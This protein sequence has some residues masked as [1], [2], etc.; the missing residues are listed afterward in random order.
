MWREVVDAVCSRSFRWSVGL[1]HRESFDLDFFSEQEVNSAYLMR[2]LTSLKVVLG[3]SDIIHEEQF[4]FNFFV[5][6]YINK[7]KLKSPRKRLC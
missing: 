4:G 5:L 7:D 2:W 3:I 1:R 6:T